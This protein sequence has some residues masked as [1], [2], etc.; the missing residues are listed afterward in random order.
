MSLLSPT[1]PIAFD[2]EASAIA[3]LRPHIDGVVFEFGRHRGLF[4]P[5]VW[6]ELPK[7]AEFMAHLK[8][9]A[10]LPMDFWKD[11]VRLSRFTVSKWKE[12]AA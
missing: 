11:G 3:A 9:K 7:P 12:S 6:E 1:E 2:D 10:G 8:N 4:L 5:Q